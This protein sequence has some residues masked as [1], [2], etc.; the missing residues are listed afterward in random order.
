MLITEDTYHYVKYFKQSKTL[1]PHGLLG[2]MVWAVFLYFC[3]GFKKKDTVTFGLPKELES[4]YIMSKLKTS[5]K[6]QEMAKRLGSII[7]NFSVVSFYVYFY[8]SVVPTKSQTVIL[9]L[10]NWHSPV[11]VKPQSHV[12][13]ASAMQRWHCLGGEG[14][15]FRICWHLPVTSQNRGNWSATDKSICASHCK[16]FL[17]PLLPVATPASTMHTTPAH[18]RIHTHTSVITAVKARTVK[19]SGECCCLYIWCMAFVAFDL[20]RLVKASVAFVCVEQW[21]KVSCGRSEII[22]R[23]SKPLWILFTLNNLLC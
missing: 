23:S 15:R 3:C 20:G 12:S 21:I 8:A 1:F 13:G 2:T 16:H 5:A 14:E 6:K 9:W 4:N 10:W 11:G 7:F 22:T 19:L 18:T 17:P